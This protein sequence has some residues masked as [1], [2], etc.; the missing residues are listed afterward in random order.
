MKQSV[1]KFK[2]INSEHFYVNNITNMA[3]MQFT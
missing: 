1:T 3:T 2:Q